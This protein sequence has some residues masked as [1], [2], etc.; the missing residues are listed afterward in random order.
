MAL[1]YSSFGL[2]KKVYLIE[3]VF[4]KKSKKDENVNE[5]CERKQLVDEKEKERKKLKKI[6]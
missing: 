3:M 4:K 1:F 5:L 6:C 2:Y